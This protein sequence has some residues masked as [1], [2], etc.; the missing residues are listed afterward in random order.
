MLNLAHFPKYYDESIIL[1][2]IPPNQDLVY[3]PQHQL[4]TVEIFKPVTK[5]EIKKIVWASKSTSCP[6]DALPTTL[7]KNVWRSFYLYLINI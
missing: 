3:E 2:S 1:E 7:L 5:E 4:S 6:L